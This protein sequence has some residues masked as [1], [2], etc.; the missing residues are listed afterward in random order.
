MVFRMLIA[1][2][3][4]ALTQHIIKIY[5][6]PQAKRLAV[7]SKPVIQTTSD[8]SSVMKKNEYTFHLKEKHFA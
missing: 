8:L 3:N 6:I 5:L 7:P 4:S 1:T 2:G